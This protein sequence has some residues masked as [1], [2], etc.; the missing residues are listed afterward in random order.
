[1]KSPSRLGGALATSSGGHQAVPPRGEC[2]RHASPA[3]AGSGD[4]MA[5]SCEAM[6]TFPQSPPPAVEDSC[7][8]LSVPGYRNEPEGEAPLEHSSTSDKEKLELLTPAKPGSAFKTDEEK[9]LQSVCFFG[10]PGKVASDYLSHCFLPHQG[11]A[12]THTPLLCSLILWPSNW[13]S[14]MIRWWGGGIALASS[15][16]EHQCPWKWLPSP[17]TNWE[18]P[19]AQGRGWVVG[20]PPVNLQV[21]SQVLTGVF[22]LVFIQNHIK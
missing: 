14:G 15:A 16:S 9:S 22:Q 12:F 3:A 20:C 8:Q 1:M 17:G 4:K 6:R 7:P 19:E 2:S 10:I 11:S 18:G 13:R 21:L 5:A